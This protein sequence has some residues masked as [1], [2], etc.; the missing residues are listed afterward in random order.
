MWE[1]EIWIDANGNK[2]L[3]YDICEGRVTYL[4]KLKGLKISR[5]DLT[6]FKKHF[7]YELHKEIIQYKTAT[8]NS[9]KEALN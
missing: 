3:I 1:G 7:C 8:F 9:I 6:S 5:C 2:R 4:Y